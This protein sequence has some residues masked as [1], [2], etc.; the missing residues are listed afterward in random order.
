MSAG[1]LMG[2]IRL[3]VIGFRLVFRYDVRLN[4]VWK[5]VAA[6]DSVRNGIGIIVCDRMEYRKRKVTANCRF[7]YSGSVGTGRFAG[8]IFN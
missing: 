8:F 7:R 5:A 1:A 3:L 4:F 2:G 6:A